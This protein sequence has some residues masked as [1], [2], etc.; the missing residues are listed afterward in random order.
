M[1][2]YIIYCIHH[3]M[4]TLTLILV[5]DEI[6]ARHK[7]VMIEVDLPE[8]TVYHI[9]VLIAEEVRLLREKLRRFH[10]SGNMVE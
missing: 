4:D 7:H 8:S 9:E 2:H 10:I 5:L 6:I 1:L 3:V